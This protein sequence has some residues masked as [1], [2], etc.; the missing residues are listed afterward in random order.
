MTRAPSIGTPAQRRGM[1]LTSI[2]LGF[3][4]L[5]AAFALTLDK[6]AILADPNVALGCNV[7]TLV[8]CSTN[9]NSARGAVT[10]PFFL[11]VV[12]H[13]L[14]AGVIPAPR[15]VRRSARA[16]FGW[17]PLVTLGYY[18]VLVALAQWKLNIIGAFFG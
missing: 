7:S 4:G 17:I 15:A 12:V 18:L 9:L 13:A 11:V 16:A 14:R 2:A 1:A 3:I 5:A 8:G 10:I 6:L